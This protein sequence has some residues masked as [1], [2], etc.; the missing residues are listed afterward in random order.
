MKKYLTI[1][2]SMLFVLG[3]V[4]SSF[5][6]HAEIPAE[7][8]AVVA[9]GTTQITLGG[10]LRFRGEYKHNTNDQ[11]DGGTDDHIAYY[12]GRVRLHI[13]AKISDT[14]RGFVQ[15]EAGDGKTKDT[16]VWGGE[17][18]AKGLYQQGDAKRGEFNLLQAWIMYN[19]GPIGIK[20]GHMPL[21]LGNKLFFEHTK[22]G[23]DAIVLFAQPNPATHVALLT[24]KFREGNTGINDDA[25]AYVLLARYKNSVFKIGGD[26]T[27][28]DDQQPSLAGFTGYDAIH[29][30]NIGLRGDINLN[31]LVLRGD[32]ELQ[33]GKFVVPGG[34]D[35]DIKGYALLA[36]LDYK[37]A[38]S[39]LTAEFAYGSGDDNAAD[40][41]F[42]TFITSLSGVQHYTYVYEYRTKS[43]VGATNTG[44]ANTWYIKLGASTK[45]NRALSLKGAVYVLRAAEDVSLNGGTADKDLGWEID[46]KISYKL[47]RNLEYYVEGGYFF[48]GDAYDYPGKE[49]DNAYAIRHGIQLK[50]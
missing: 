45:V 31:A 38:N 14:V 29:L 1:M 37:I 25:N 17:S 46:G 34:N 32:V 26:V 33:T 8:Q 9:K 36:G 18:G 30:W 39:T 12:D 3:L 24:A 16:W 27:Y 23:D 6:I 22:F 20:V 21:A 19:P 28:V 10:S 47:A 49:A 43:A 40:D 48:T 15:V 50:F 11:I 7:T 41:N 13:N 5:A 35:L 42:E 2:L 4:A 44:L